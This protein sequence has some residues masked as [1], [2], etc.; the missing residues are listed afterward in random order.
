M[1]HGHRQYTIRLIHPA[2]GKKD[3]CRPGRGNTNGIARKK[4]VDWI[5]NPAVAWQY[6]NVDN[7]FAGLT[8]CER[9]HGTPRLA[10]ISQTSAAARTIPPGVSATRP[11]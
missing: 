4:S 1:Y 10:A 6:M 5:V 7:L 11:I 8:G 3:A 2:Q 9:P